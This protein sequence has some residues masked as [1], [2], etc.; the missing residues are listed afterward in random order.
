MRPDTILHPQLAR[1]LAELGHTDTFMV[2]DA[3]FPVP[4]GVERIDLG[5]WPGLPTVVQVLE[6]MRRAVFVE[7]VRFAPEVATH[8]P[9]LYA[10]LQRIYTGSGATFA[11]STHEQL[12]EEFA[13]RAKFVVRSGDFQPWGNV[14]LVAST[15]PFAWFGDEDV[16]SG[17]QIL[18]AYTDRRHRIDAGAVPDLT[19][20]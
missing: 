13:P 1:A 20:R 17:L 5:F 15:D 8:N 14:L 2:L 9:R 3:G 11:A 16:A 19:T 18:P 4:G 6:V 12:I 7:E 10:E